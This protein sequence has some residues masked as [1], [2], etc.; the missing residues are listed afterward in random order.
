MTRLDA[1]QPK[2]ARGIVQS[3]LR[4]E[5]LRHERVA[6]APDLASFIEHF[7]AVW[8]NRDLAGPF[9]AQTLPHPSVHVTIE[10]RAHEVGGVHSHRFVRTLTG[11]GRVF[12]VKFRPGMFE[13]FLGGSVKRLAN[14]TVGLR[15]VFGP[16]AVSWGRQV[17]AAPTMNGCVELAETFFRKRLPALDPLAVQVRDVIEHVAFDRE[18]VRVDQVAAW[19][20]LPIRTLQR[21]FAHYA[22]VS[23]KWVLAR[24]RLHEAMERLA[25]HPRLNLANLALELGY[26][27][28]AHF[29]RDFKAVVGTT[30]SAYATST[31]KTAGL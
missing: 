2:P 20:K 5:G 6:P 10:A 27:D 26:T 29:A 22:G 15:E 31:Q 19:A 16:Q 13:G 25:Q 30:P 18:L 17:Q 7:W 14:R 24:Y 4:P 21:R 28:Q 8:W 9:V 1:A 12:G 11:H 3:T 23:V